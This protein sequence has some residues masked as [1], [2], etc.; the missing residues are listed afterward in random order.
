M[1]Y[2]YRIDR[3]GKIRLK[4][5][6]TDA[7]GGLDRQEAERKSAELG[8]E[9]DEPAELLF[10]AG[11]RGLPVVLQGRDTSGKDGTLRPYRKEWDR[12]LAEVGRK[13]RAEPAAYRRGR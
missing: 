10:A 7:D 11:R 1:A 2:A 5:Y 6:K 8:R 12:H 4:K 13:A 3:P 9:L